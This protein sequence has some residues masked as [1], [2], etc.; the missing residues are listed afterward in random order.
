MKCGNCGKENSPGSNFCGS[1]GAELD[2]SYRCSHC[3]EELPK[4]SR[5]C[6]YCGTKVKSGPSAAARVP[7]REN[8]TGYVH[9]QKKPSTKRKPRL[10]RSNI[11]AYAVVLVIVLGAAG[12]FISAFP[13]KASNVSKNNLNTGSG[14]NLVWSQ[15]VQSIASNFN[16]PCG[17]CGVTR[18]D[19]CTCDAIKGAVEV[20]NYIQR[21]INQGLP[22]QEIIV[23]VEDRYGN[24]I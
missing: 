18:L 3:G 24:R 5:Y 6:I 8:K 11:I 7:Y 2:K 10:T 20:K 16:C 1:C 4:K 23:K 22:E 13:N 17:A 9:K 14:N 15:N 19:V 12:Y 21:F